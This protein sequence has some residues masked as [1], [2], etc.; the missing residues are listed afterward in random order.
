MTKSRAPARL[1]EETTRAVVTRLIVQRFP[2]GCRMNPAYGVAPPFC[3][4]RAMD[5][6]RWSVGSVSLA[7]FFR[8]ASLPLCDSLVNSMTACWCACSC[9]WAY[10][11]SKLAPL[12]GRSR[13]S[14]ARCFCIERRRRFEARFRG[15]D[16]LQLIARLGVVARH[17]V[18]EAP[19]AV[20]DVIVEPVW[21]KTGADNP[22]ARKP[23]RSRAVRIE[24]SSADS[25][26]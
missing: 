13:L 17:P 21:P 5:K 18:G 9:C 2:S 4:C 24:S 7:N 8:S 16:R 6:C 22:A 19:G 1:P 25:S 20:P 14:S 12:A 3:S 26:R 11:R 15:K 10:K 23:A